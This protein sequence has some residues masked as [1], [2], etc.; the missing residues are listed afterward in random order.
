MPHSPHVE[1]SSFQVGTVSYGIERYRD[2]ADARRRP[3]VVLLHGV[4]GLGG[5]SGAE[6]RALA[7]R[8]AEEGYLVALPRYFDAEDGADTLPLEE[9]FA[10]R[11]PRVGLYGPRIAAAVDDT[12]DHAGADGNRLA[13]IGASLG[14]GLALA[15]AQ[16]APAGTIKAVVDLFGYIGDPRIFANV[17]RLPPTL[18]LHNRDDRVVTVKSSSAPLL[19]ALAGTSVE[20]DHEFFDEDY[21][22]RRNHSFRPGGEVEAKART[23]TLQWLA[24]YVR[25]AA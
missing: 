16:S 1:S 25:D 15:H 17:D 11:V 6:L 20:H 5:Q 13:L 19:H 7:A 10:R 4:D 22:E 3:A 18:I 8:I 9:M 2:A 21:D 14:G 12:I 24:K 23:R